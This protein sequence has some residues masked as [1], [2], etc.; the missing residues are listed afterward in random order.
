MDFVA[1]VEL[2]P[3]FP[4]RLCPKAAHSSRTVYCPSQERM[5]PIRREAPSR[6]GLCSAGPPKGA[7]RRLQSRCQAPSVLATRQVL[8]FQGGAAHPGPFWRC[9]ILSSCFRRTAICCQPPT[10]AALFPCLSLAR[11]RP[12]WP[13][14]LSVPAPVAFLKVKSASAHANVMPTSAHAMEKSTSA[15]AVEKSISAHAKESSQPPK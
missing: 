12:A 15:P 5:V 10:L 8:A 3:R 6:S 4:S 13:P 1:T 7:P 14:G 2:A 9:R 11:L